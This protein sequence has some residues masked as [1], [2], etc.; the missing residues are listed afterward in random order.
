[1][2]LRKRERF[3]RDA[4]AQLEERDD[5]AGQGH[6]T[7]KHAKEHLDRVDVGESPLEPFLGQERVV[8]DEHGCGADKAVQDRDQL[9][10]LRHLDALGPPEAND[11]ADRHRDDDQPEGGRDAQSAFDRGCLQGQANGRDDG[12]DHTRNTV[13]V[14]GLGGL[15]LGEAG[16]GHDEQQSGDDVCRLDDGGHLDSALPEHREHALG[17]GETTEDV[18]A[19]DRQGDEGHDRDNAAVADLAEGTDQDD[20]GDGVGL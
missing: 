17:H 15:V 2:A 19:G 10:H 11:R 5:R 12:D 13:G 7:D 4:S 3:G 20:S 9:G 1:M 18:D 16:Q 8:A 14:T 6:G